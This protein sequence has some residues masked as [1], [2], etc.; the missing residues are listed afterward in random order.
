[1]FSMSLFNSSGPLPAGGEDKAANKLYRCYVVSSG[2]NV[3]FPLE[4]KVAFNVLGKWGLFKM[5]FS[6]NLC[7]IINFMFINA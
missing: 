3:Y 4:A 7:F 2:Q 5:L 1:M 6:I